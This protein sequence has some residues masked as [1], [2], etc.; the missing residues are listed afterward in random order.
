MVYLTKKIKSLSITNLKF[1]DR[2]FTESLLMVDR[3]K[4]IFKML[5]EN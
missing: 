5:P 2:T 1:I 3:S 4:A